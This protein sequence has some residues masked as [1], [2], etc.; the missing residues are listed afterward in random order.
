ME[1]I[2]TLLGLSMVLIGLY[3]GISQP[4]V[5]LDWMKV[6]GGEKDQIPDNIY[7]DYK[8]NIVI[9]GTFQVGAGY[10]WGLIETNLDGD[11]LFGFTL[12]YD[13]KSSILKEMIPTLDSGWVFVGGIPGPEPYTGKSDI[14][15]IKLDKDYDLFFWDRI[16]AIERSDGVSCITELTNGYF[17]IAGFE[18]FEES[19]HDVVLHYLTPMGEVINR[20]QYILTF[21]SDLCYDICHTAGGGF[22]FTG[23]VTD[24]FYYKDA[25]IY[26]LNAGADSV[27]YHT[28]GHDNILDESGRRI[29]QTSDG[30]F[31]VAGDKGAMNKKFYVLKTN[32]NGGKIWDHEMG[33]TYVQMAYSAIETHDGGFVACGD[34]FDYTWKSLVV[35]YN[36]QG[37]TLWTIQ[38]GS[39]QESL[40]AVDILQ[41]PDSS[42]IVTGTI[43]TGDNNDRDIFV[44]RL[45][46]TLTPDDTD[47][48]DLT[49]GEIILYPNPAIGFT[50]L[51][52]S[53]LHH[54]FAKIELCNNLG[55]K[56]KELDVEF[57]PGENMV[58][59]DMTG[60]VPGLYFCRLDCAHSRS[61][62]LK[63][64]VR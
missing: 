64:V 35:R 58:H 42:F 27:W 4:G 24:E 7:L 51:K 63:L 60:V 9:G 6:Y 20:I 53:A 33:G 39:N 44:A 46:E 49:L 57:H 59:L 3:P 16:G 21:D 29:R 30:G 52:V 28:F 22:A 12:S 62:A 34:F 36:E 40:S 54:E 43:D 47:N 41:L 11:S 50:T 25:F 1:K 17:V 10:K 18:W 38:W 56:V 37:D 13:G 45:V 31:I 14:G 19:V 8:G 48:S 2:K 5:T 23:S 15:I 61:K 55:L 26:H 32:A